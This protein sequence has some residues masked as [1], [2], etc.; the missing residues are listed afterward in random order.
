MS[1]MP[2][3]AQTSASWWERKA[4]PLST[5]RRRRAA[6]EHGLLQHRQEGG[7]AL[8]EGEGGVGDH[9]RRV[10][11]ERDEVRLALLAGD[12]NGRSV[13]HVA[14]PQVAR[15]LEGEATVVLRRGLA[16][17]LRHELGA[18]G[19]PSG[20]FPV[21]IASRMTSWTESS[22]FSSLIETRRSETSR[23]RACD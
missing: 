7:G 5:K 1:V 14:H 6:A 11:D 15:L 22:R 16:R 9:P 23:G 3:F 2:S 20:I 19:R 17:L 12:G 18:S 10:V 4:L 8:G 13:H 21:A